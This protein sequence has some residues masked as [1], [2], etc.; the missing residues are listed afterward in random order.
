MSGDPSKFHPCTIL[1]P[2]SKIRIHI[3]KNICRK[4]GSTPRRAMWDASSGVPLLTS[5]SCARRR[6]VGEACELEGPL[7]QPHILAPSWGFTWTCSAVLSTPRPRTLISHVHMYTGTSLGTSSRLRVSGSFTAYATACMAAPPSSSTPSLR[8]PPY[9]PHTPRTSRVSWR[10]RC[11]STTSTTQGIS[12]RIRP[13][14]WALFLPCQRAAHGR[15]K[16]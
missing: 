2:I 1:A 4:A 10:L 5:L 15:G 3:F 13:S 7:R 11:R 6:D 12:M 14:R 9:V 16:L 8:S